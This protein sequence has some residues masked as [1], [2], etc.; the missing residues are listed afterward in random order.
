MLPSFGNHVRSYNLVAAPL[1]EPLREKPWSVPLVD[2]E[3][4]VN[5]P[6]LPVVKQPVVK[7]PVVKQPVVKQ[8]VKPVVGPQPRVI[9]SSRA[10][11][12]ADGR[13]QTDAQQVRVGSH[14][15]ASVANGR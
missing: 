7:Q 6:P 8:P 9:K 13:L 2:W 4:H 5:L 14:E 1:T 3:R 12:S 10:G 11:I 15:Q